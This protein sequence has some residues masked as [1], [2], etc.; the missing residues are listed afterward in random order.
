LFDCEALPTVWQMTSRVVAQARAGVGLAEIFQALF[1]CGS[2]TGAPKLRAM[3][4]IKELEASPR[5]IYCGA[6]G[7]VQPGGAARF[8]VPIRTVVLRG[9]EA[10]CG[11]GSGITAGANAAAE[12]NEW[13]SKSLFLEQASAPFRLLQTL[14][15]EDGR[16]IH[17]ELHL[18][19]LAAASAQFGFAFD[20]QAARE[21]LEAAG[22][23][24]ALAACRGRV[25]VGPAAD[26]EVELS[27]LPAT[28][29]G[30]LPVRLAAR[31]VIAPPAFLR[32]KTTR[33]DHLR[34]F[35]TDPTEAF[36]TLLWNEHGEVTEFTR[37]N[38]I[39]ETAAGERV[40][41]PLHCGLLD[42]VGRAAELA[43]GRVQERVVRTEELG[44]ARG[45]WF[46]NALRGVLP[47]RLR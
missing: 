46:V 6:V 3:H 36:D 5:G 38:V 16:W 23:R 31:P 10:V 8:N 39:V 25:L 30:I 32:H 21:A 44:T 41:P 27:A 15:R 19:R 33:R 42:G 22:A 43:A 11:I 28:P 47:V 26:V 45:I 1:P 2:V 18:D 4:W 12:W 35:E 24:S 20:R 29:A 14:R 37:G 13:A 40:T 9:D 17:L 34:P 7:V